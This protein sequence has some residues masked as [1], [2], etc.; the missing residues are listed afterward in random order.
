M[1]KKPYEVGSKPPEGYL[2]WHAWAEA[3][4][5]GGLRQK[6]CNKCGLYHFPQETCKEKK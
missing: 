3:Q 1:E 6:K 4:Y 2:T 5:E